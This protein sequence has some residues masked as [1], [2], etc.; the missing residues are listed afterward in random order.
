[1]AVRLKSYLVAPRLGRMALRSS[2]IL[3]AVTV[4]PGSVLAGAGGAGSVCAAAEAMP[5]KRPQTEVTPLA[6]RIVCLSRWYPISL[7]CYIITSRSVNPHIDIG[8]FGRED[9]R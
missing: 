8:A 6:R 4:M 5:T 1:M 3:V 2:S 7:D 9:W